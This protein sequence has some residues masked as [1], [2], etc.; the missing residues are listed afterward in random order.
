VIVLHCASLCFT[1]LGFP[2]SISFWIFLSSD[3]V[4][5]PVV[6]SLGFDHSGVCLVSTCWSGVTWN[7]LEMD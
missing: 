7:K 3:K 4:V 6:F 5:F 2:E 1:V